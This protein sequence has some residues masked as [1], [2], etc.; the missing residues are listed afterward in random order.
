MEKD[1]KALEWLEGSELGYD[2]WEKKYRFNNES[3]DE[4]LDRLS[5]GDEKV[6]KLIEEKKFLY[7]GR[8][9]ANLNT[10]NGQGLSN[11]TTFSYVEDS[12][13]DIMDTAK[14]LAISYKKEA[15]VGIAL[16]KIRPK[17]ASIGGNH[18]SDG[19]IGFLKIFNSVTENVKRGGARRGAM[20]VGLHCDHPDIFDF[21][22]IKKQNKGTDGE[23][24]SAN[25]SVLVTDEFMEHYIKGE[26][27]RKDFVVEATGEVIPHIVDT[28]KIINAIVD[29]PKTAF[30]PGIIFVDRYKEGHLFGNVYDDKELMCNA[31]CFTGDEKLLTHDGYKR[32]DEIVDTMPVIINKNGELSNSKIWCSGVKEVYQVKSNKYNIAKCTSNHVFLTTDGKE[33]EAINLVGKQIM[34]N[35][36]EN[37]KKEDWFVKL[38]FI[39][40]HGGTGRIESKCHKGL[41]IY[42]G[43]ND[44]DI[45]KYFDI[46]TKPYQS[47]P[48]CYYVKF[49]L[50]K[51]RELGVS[52]KRAHEREFPSTY[53]DWTI[54]QKASFLK[55]LFSANGYV[56]NKYGRIGL[57]T[58][59][60]NEAMSVLK[61]LSEDFEIKAYITTSKPKI[62]KW[63]NGVYTSKESYDVNISEYKSKLKF[64]ECI[65]FIHQ[66]KK[67]ILKQTLIEQAP[68]ITSVKYIGTEKVYDFEEPN[69]H[70]GVVNGFVVHNS[71]FYGAKGTVCLL[72][73]INLSAYVV[74][75]FG[76]TYFDFDGF[77]KD[78][79]I[80]IKA[81]DKAHDYGIGKNGLKIQNDRAE[82]YR[83]IG[84]G[85]MGL[86]DMFIKLGIRYGS[87]ESIVLSEKIAKIM[88][89]SS[90][91]ESIQLGKE[92]GQPK[93]I[94]EDEKKLEAMG[95]PYIKG[96]RNNSLLS[97]APAGSISL[98]ANVSTGIEPVFRT[99]YVRKTESLNN[100][101]TY[102]TVYHKAIQDVI[103]RFGYKP[104]YCIDTR[105]ITVHE[106]VDVIAAWQKYVDLSISNTTNFKENATVDEIRELY[107]YGW[108]KGVKGL[109]VYVDGSI[110]GV[111]NDVGKKEETT[112]L[113]RGEI[114][115][116]PDSLVGERVEINHG[117]GKYTL[118][119]YKDTNTG[120]V[121]DCWIN[122][123]TNGCISNVQSLAVTISLLLRAGVDLD[124]I[125]TAI[126]GV[127]SCPSFMVGKSQGRCS[128]GKSCGTAIITA[129][130]KAQG[131][132]KPEIKKVEKIETKDTLKQN[133]KIDNKYICPECGAVLHPLGGC[134]SCEC[135]FTKCE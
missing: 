95:L 21:I 125:S 17:G 29:T 77:S 79:K 12:L 8:I 89:E 93:G 11:C 22:N 91:E 115:K 2:V 128:E 76:N 109:T 126:S 120:K 80:C 97:I 60:K 107:R 6:R 33:I 18:K 48:Y 88:R 23:V 53:D 73:S 135:G 7:G 78:V 65:N 111:L 75:D 92:L 117:C 110:E 32:F 45:Y 74:E 101:N 106:K 99:S 26:S 134:F 5:N 104:D 40:G 66:Y 41:E 87:K 42:I 105:D 58:S 52:S 13:D 113:K 72:G 127:G 118:H 102:Y 82:Q 83:G 37:L 64:S 54:V 61:T 98:I 131:N 96:L 50:D 69:L 86:A 90:I 15:G 94:L 28:V 25:L 56:L 114:A 81:L 35:L 67:D 62:V 20:L 14:N 30:E 47:K 51:M 44:Y 1:I 24:T 124:R 112:E 34:P 85:I 123:K 59:S 38:G 133:K 100:T 19:I 49:D 55:G 16:S 10:G 130:K 57:K 43:K 116:K 121:F 9:L 39:Q 36:N 103:D 70:F 129:L 46:S 122:S 4:W 68:T 132:I 63:H 27:Y 3:F 31:C 108:E 71:E 119:I 84:L